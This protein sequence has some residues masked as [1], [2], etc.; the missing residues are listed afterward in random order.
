MQLEYLE[1]WQRKL[2]EITRVKLK[3][4]SKIKKNLSERQ[5]YSVHQATP[6]TSFF[7]LTLNVEAQHCN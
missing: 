3:K 4:N 7:R 5:E 6:A 2:G 1:K